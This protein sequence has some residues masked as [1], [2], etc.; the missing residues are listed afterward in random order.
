MTRKRPSDGSIVLHID[1]DLAGQT[2]AAAVRTACPELSWATCRNRI[3]DCHVQVDGNLC[4]DAGRRLKSGEV[5]KIHQKPRSRPPGVE[6]I[7]LVHLDSDVVVINKPAGMNS[8]RHPGER[9]WSVQRKQFQPTLDEL[10]P[11]LLRQHLAN[12]TASGRPPHRDRNR[13]TRSRK[14]TPAAGTRVI[15]VHRLDRETSGLMVFA[16][17]QAAAA[18]LISQFSRHTIGRVYFAIAHGSVAATKCDTIIVRDRGDGIRGSV[19]ASH[20]LASAGQ[21][22]VTHLRPLRQFPNGTL[23]ECRLET[24]RTHQIR[25]HLSELGHPLWGD[26][27]YRGGPAGGGDPAGTEAAPRVALHAVLLSFRHPGSGAEVCF[28]SRFPEDL[29]QLLPFPAK[30]IPAPRGNVM[31]MPAADPPH[32]ANN[33]TAR[34]VS[35]PRKAPARPAPPGRSASAPPRPQRKPAKR[36][37]RS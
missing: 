31:A 11:E 19:A 20:P 3:R 4:L 5:V 33:P 6:D 32:A 12:R 24:G 23:V 1:R 16:R 29:A 21:R 30:E 35:G 37:K 27:V 28:T 2:L 36:R 25:I 8:V 18:S 14:A 7:G 15:P 9:N 26:R 13:A 34:P 22:A 10:V 17:H